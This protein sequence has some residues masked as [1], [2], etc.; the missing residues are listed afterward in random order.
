M[1]ETT[2]CPY[3]DEDIGK[4]DVYCRHCGAD[5]K[6]ASAYMDYPE[7]EADSLPHLEDEGPARGEHDFSE[8]DYVPKKKTGFLVPALII[9]LVLAM[10]AGGV[11]YLLYDETE[12][13]AEE[14]PLEVPEA[15]REA[16][17]EPGVT[18]P[19]QRDPEPDG[20]TGPGE[21][22]EAEEAEAEP[23]DY[24]QLEP[25]LEEWLEERLNDPDVILVHTDELD[26][27]DQF[28]EEY[29]LEEDNV[30]VYDIQSTDEEFA[31][32]VFGLPFSQWSINAVFIWRDGE[33][34]FLR[35]GT[36]IN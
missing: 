24:E 14:E 26:D 18:E 4:E 10:T 1:D 34:H 21:D 29:D 3:C 27:V 25:V 15:A 33:W 22:E 32:V 17:P 35:E 20:E 13:A 6:A 7:D 31:S 36:V 9:C 12:Q 23:P 11:Y 2:A 5:L 8:L 19:E 28:F 16:E 30:I